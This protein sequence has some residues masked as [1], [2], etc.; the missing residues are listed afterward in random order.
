MGATLDHALGRSLKFFVK[1]ESAAG[2]AYGTDSQEALVGTDAAKILSS[3]IDF[4]IAREDRADSR[5]TRSLLDRI[6][7][8][9]EITW[10]CESYLLPAGSSTAPDIDPL[11]ECAMGGAFGASVAK[12]YK[13][14]DTNALPTAHI[15]REANGVLR[16]DLFGVWVEEMKIAGS[17][18]SIAAKSSSQVSMKSTT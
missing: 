12:T 6:T 3:S 11:I 13:L 9:Q 4:Q 17:G 10:S 18:M 8:K 15:A 14:T 16:E 1:K 5:T 7:G 2:G